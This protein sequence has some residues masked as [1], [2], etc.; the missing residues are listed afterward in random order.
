[1]FQ[2]DEED[3]ERGDEGVDD[4]RLDQHQAEE[5]READ[6]RGSAG[7][8]GEGLTGAGNRA[9]LGRGAKGGGDGDRPGRRNHRPLAHHRIPG[10]L[11]E[12]RGSGEDAEDG[13][14]GYPRLVGHGCFLLGLVVN[15]P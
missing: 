8:S 5:Q 11:G 9:S 14:Q 15:N 10:P 7:V 1:M 6:L 12:D 4:E 3:D 13:Q 2:A